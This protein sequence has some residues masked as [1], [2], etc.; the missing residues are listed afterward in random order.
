MSITC[1]RLSQAFCLYISLAGAATVQAQ[2]CVPGSFGSPPNDL[3]DSVNSSFPIQ[4]ESTH[5]QIRWPGDKPSLLTREQAQA[6][7]AGME[8][9]LSWFT[10]PSVKWPE[11]YCDS[12]VKYKFQIFT[13]NGYGLSGAGAGDREPAMWVDPDALIAMSLGDTSGMVHEFT[14]SMQ[15]HSK[16][17]R[18]TQFGGWMWESHAEF[19]ASQ[20]PGNP[21]KTGCSA[22]SAWMPH[23]YYGSTRVRYCNWQF[24]DHIKNK[25]G[26]SAVNDIFLKTAGITGQDPLVVLMNNQRWTTAMLGDEFGQ[27]AMR[28][29]TWDYVDRQDGFNR[30]DAYRMAYGPIT[31]LGQVADYSVAKRLRVSRLEAI[32]L[33]NRRFVVSNY[34]APQRY[35]YNHVKLVPDAGAKRIS[36]KFGGIVQQTIAP[37]AEVGT[38]AFQPGAEPD[39]TAFAMPANPS[40]SWRWGVVAIDLNGKPRYS[41]MQR[42]TAGQLDFALRAG[43]RGVYLVVAA[44]PRQ[45][46]SIFWDQMYHTLYRYPYTVELAG[47]MPDGFQPGYRQDVANGFPA[48]APHPNGGGWVAH[49][50]EV[51][52]TAYVGPNAAVLGG[53]VLGSARIED[54]AVVWNGTVQDRAVV[55]GLTQLQADVT[56]AGKAS[57]RSVMAGGQTFEGGTVIKGTTI[58]FGDLETHQGSTPV[59]K[60]AF[61]GFLDTQLARRPEF[62]ANRT[63]APIEVTRPIPAYWPVTQPSMQRP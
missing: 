62:G 34:F 22:L 27:Y 26:F 57:I 18:D 24:W 2:S 20:Y 21:D 38:G 61:S 41:P 10:G 49:G 45:H 29:V 60:G 37:G 28:N 55:G 4:A 36:V 56:V 42:G 8:D 31:D 50:A 19:M 13:D 46:H 63:A 44:T 40:S 51:A 23:L 59:S 58:L 12:A 47:A 7:L 43:D 6:A 48:G 25:H 33:P 16:G 11:P 53:R 15:F 5:F 17:L 1:Q 3:W 9:I 32:D 39:W 35:G 14:H 30:G 52:T 54:Y